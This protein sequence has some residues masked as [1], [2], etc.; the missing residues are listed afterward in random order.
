MLGKKLHRVS[1]IMTELDNK[2]TEMLGVEAEFLFQDI[3][4]IEPLRFDNRY[5]DCWLSNKAFIDFPDGKTEYIKLLCN[6]L[7]NR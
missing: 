4:Q 6:I 7:L 2:V 5:N 1:D 3:K